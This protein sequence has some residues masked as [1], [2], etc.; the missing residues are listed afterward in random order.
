[1]IVLLS[2]EGPTDLGHCNNTQGQ[3]RDV[4]FEAGP[5]TVLLDRLIETSRLGYSLLDIPEAYR[6]V[7]ETTLAQRDADR[8]RQ[9]RNTFLAGKKQ[10]KETGYFHI[11]AWI[12]GEIAKEHEAKAGDKAVA[13]LFRDCD[14]TRSAKTGIWQEKW[15]S[16]EHGFLRAQFERGVPMLPKPKSE[17]WLLCAAKPNPYQNCADLENSLSGND[18]SPNSAKK[19]LGKILPDTSASGLKTWM[20]TALDIDRIDMPSFNHAHVGK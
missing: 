15:N 6:Y 20:E 5:M 10:G 7:D 14:G 19:Q 13:V 18:A 17:A 9:K 11:N 12:L 3:C 8:K 16:M 4:D 2:G 1:M